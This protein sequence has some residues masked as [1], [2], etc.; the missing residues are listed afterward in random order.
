MVKF[1]NEIDPH[2]ATIKLRESV[3]RVTRAVAL[4]VEGLAKE[5]IL[6]PFEHADGD[7]RGQVDTGAMVNTT[8][9]IFDNV[10]AGYDAAV[11]VS[12]HY[13]PYQEAIR[14]FLWPAALQVKDEFDQVASVERREFG[15]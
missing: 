5:N 1:K 6:K 10:P 4:R 14:A 12:A 7:V 3:E 2:Y 11:I 13:A 9:A 8:R 15:K